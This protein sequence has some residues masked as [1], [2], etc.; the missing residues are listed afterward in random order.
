VVTELRN[1][2]AMRDVRTL[3]KLGDSVTGTAQSR[4]AAK[5]DVPT[6]S[7]KV[8]SVGIMMEQSRS[9]AKKD[10]P[11]MSSKGECVGFMEQLIRNAP[12]KGAIITPEGK[13]ESVSGTGLRYNLF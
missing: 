9:A 3:L 12:R 11:T 7:S 10:V 8:E 2:V 1:H 13:K 4:S 6:T 5:K